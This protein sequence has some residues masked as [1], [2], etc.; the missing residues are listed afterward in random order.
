MQHDIAITPSNRQ[1]PFA[2]N[3]VSSNQRCVLVVGLGPAGLSAATQFAEAG[4]HVRGYDKRASP[5]QI[6]AVDARGHAFTLSPKGRGALPESIRQKVDPHCVELDSRVFVDRYGSRRSYLYGDLPQDRLHA[7]GRSDFQKAALVA[8]KAAGADLN[9]SSPVIDINPLT[10]QITICRGDDSE[11]QHADLVVAADGAHSGARSMC[12]AVTGSSLT[13]RFDGVRYVSVPV[14]MEETQRLIGTNSGLHFF[15][16]KHGT[17]VFIPTP[18]TSTLLVMS[19]LIPRNGALTEDS[20]RE[21]ARSRNLVIRQSIQSLDSRLIGAPIGHFVNC[22][23]EV[24]YAGRVAIVGDAWIATP[25]YAGQ[26]VN[27]ALQDVKT[28][29]DSV[30]SEATIE[31][32]LKEYAARRGASREAIRDLNATIGEQLLTGSYG[33]VL[34]RAK[35]WLHT[36]IGVRT[37][38]QKLVLDEA[39]S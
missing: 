38:Y 22:E 3:Q 30:S 7:V 12:A 29:V 32:A 31:S 19:R 23:T 39:T 25:A 6:Q 8:A 2:I 4:W 24:P 28:L 33:G 34:W 15:R 14:S 16:S 37:A 13:V 20:A 5:D 10:G 35:Q 11:R 18:P 27:S 26:G 21:L 36:K 17:D 1:T 9:F